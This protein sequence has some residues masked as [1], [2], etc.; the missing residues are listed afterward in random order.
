MS[1]SFNDS[2]VYIRNGKP[3]PAIVLSSLMSDRGELLT[4]LYAQPEIGPTL[5]A[6]GTTRG[7]AQVQQAVAPFKEGNMFGWKPW[8]EVAPTEPPTAPEQLDEAQGAVEPGAPES[9]HAPGFASFHVAENEDG[10]LESHP[11]SYPE[12]N[13]PS[14]SEREIAVQKSLAVQE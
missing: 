2:V 1:H 4:V 12:N 10:T 5:L 8:G 7:I 3:I 11:G 14:D 6:Q 9:P 13:P